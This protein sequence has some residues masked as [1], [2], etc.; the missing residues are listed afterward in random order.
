LI[1]LLVL[2]A[3]IAIL[4]ALLLPVLS[5][6]KAK[7][8]SIQCLSNLRQITFGFKIA[9]D[10]DSGRLWQPHAPMGTPGA[11]YQGSAMQEWRMRT[12]GKMKEGWICPTAPLRPLSPTAQASGP[13]P[14]YAGTVNSAWQTKGLVGWW[15][16]DQSAGG[17]NP[18]QPRAGSYAPNNWLSSS[19]WWSEGDG[20][21]TPPMA[22]ITDQQIEQPAGTPAYADSPNSWWWFGG[23]WAGPRAT[24]LPASNLETGSGGGMGAFTTP[25]HGSRPNRISKS[26]PPV[27][28]LPGAINV[29]FY[30]GHVE[31]VKLE[32][33][34]K[35]YWH[36]YYQPPARRPGLK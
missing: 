18:I 21:S 25:R 11:P 31:Q 32:R 20:V 17:I 14:Y 12:W 2:I 7:A 24:D 29:S 15:W 13:G 27:Q 23:V 28:L 22:F 35:L 30:D 5:K 19:I 26:H 34:W 9:V 33:L 3:I 16:W 36:R 8:Q 4:A 10:D 6:A 1:E